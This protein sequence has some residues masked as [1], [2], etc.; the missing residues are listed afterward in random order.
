VSIVENPISDYVESE[1]VGPTDTLIRSLLLVAVFLLVWISFNPFPSLPEGRQAGDEGNLTN[2]LGYSILFIM[3]AAWC[4]LH[5][6]QRLLLLLRPVLIMTV[7]WFALSVAT[8][9]DPSASARRF[10]F[11]LVTIGIAGMVL[12]LPRNPWHLSDVL[13]AVVI[14]VLALC[15]IELIASPSLAFHQVTDP[16]DAESAG[17]WRG[18]FGH[19]NGAGVTMAI[20]IFIG[21]F[22]TKMRSV[23]LG[24]A[25]VV[26]S[27][28]FLLL[29]HSRTAMAAVIL[30]YIVS[31]FIA[32]VRPVK[33]LIV[34]LGIMA[35]LNLISIGSVY[36]EAGQ[37]LAQAI[38]PDPTFT[39]RADVWKFALDH[40]AQRPITGYGFASFWGTEQVV[41]G[42]SGAGWANTAYH[43]HNGYLDLALTVGIP[44][45]ALV[46]LWLVV[47]P[48]IDYHRSPPDPTSAPL[49]ILFLRICLLA[50]YESCFETMFTQV[51]APGL[52]LIFAAF[53]LRFLAVLPVAR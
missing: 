25:I 24:T 16:H 40:V 42:M 19:K 23:A 37:A 3:L 33:G 46:M 10:A 6:P 50:C 31:I 49:K 48:L 28:V 1:R 38:M 2:Q 44:G 15:C 12:L 51:G 47:L 27:S 18:L 36:L 11:A 32:H 13:A 8:S 9:W 17:D 20:F 41:Y 35:G 30:A 43:A 21:C 52:I 26:I 34:A 22:V 5:H 4:T 7:F 29:A 39:G 45:A 53:G 14:T